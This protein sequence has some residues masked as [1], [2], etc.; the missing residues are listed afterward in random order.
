M[1]VKSNTHSTFDL[2]LAGRSAH[3][4]AI[5]GQAMGTIDASK[6]GHFTDYCITLSAIITELRAAKSVSPSS[7]YFNKKVK[8]FSYTT[9]LR[10]ASYRRIVESQFNNSRSVVEIEPDEDVEELKLKVVSLMAQTNLLKS[11][12]VELDAGRGLTAIDNAEAEKIVEKLNQRIELLIRVNR[13]VLDSVS[14]AFRL[15]LEA[16]EKQPVAGLYGPKGLVATVDDMREIEKAMK[17][18]PVTL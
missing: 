12:V 2:Y 1:N 7:P 10:N 6:F 16:S 18:H 11:R 3:I 17:E 5:I 4:E 8:A 14:G 15:I 9:L 13:D